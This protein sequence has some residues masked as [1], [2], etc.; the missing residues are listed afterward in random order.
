MNAPRPFQIS[1]SPARRGRGFLLES[2]RMVLISAVGLGCTAWPGS[3]PAAAEPAVFWASD[4]VRPGETVMILGSGFGEAGAVEVVRLPDE[5]T[6]D[7]AGP[8]AAAAPS[9]PDELAAFFASSAVQR[10]EVLQGS[11]ASLK[12]VLPPEGKPGIYAY[13]ISGANGRTAGL[14]NVPRV[15]WAQGDQGPAASPGGWLQVLG[16]NMAGAALGVEADGAAQASL[17][18]TGPRTCAL[19][20]EADAYRAR[21]DLPADLPPGEYRF[22]VIAGDL[23]DQPDAG[24]VFLRRVTVRADAYRGHLTAEQLDQR[25]REAQRLST[26]GGD[27]VRLGGQHVEITDCDLYGSGRVLFLSRVRGGLV[28]G[29]ALYNGR[30]GWY[31]LS[32]NNGLIFAHNTLTGG[33]LMSTGGGLNCLDGS[34]SSENVYYAHNQLRLLHGWDREAMTTDAGGEAYFGKLRSAQG[35][36]LE[37]DSDPNWRH[38]NWTGAGVFLL[39]GTGA[40]QHRRVVRHEGSVVEIDRPWQVAP[41]PSTDVGLTMFQGYY[42]IVDNDFTDTGAVQLYGTSVECVLAGNRGTRMA[43]FRGLGLWYHGYQPSWYCQFL[44]NEIREGN[45]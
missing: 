34:T 43:G 20:V 9:P 16:R 7:A 10:P 21:A 18:L 8:S 1:R 23:G 44:D 35:T 19:P 24:R 22:H 41:D 29:N 42:L 39:A 5:A 31:C 33:D 28:A 3:E 30:W 17:R 25:F 38:R 27:A 2:L 36:R 6:G 13:R 4:P 11:D 32:G 14:L 40:G 12:F 15:Y 45:Y 37:L 26:G